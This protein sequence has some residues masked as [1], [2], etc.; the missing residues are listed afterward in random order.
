MSVYS[1]A[2]VVW[3]AINVTVSLFL[4]ALALDRETT[5]AWR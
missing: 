3:E 1:S 5:A 4:A 2:M